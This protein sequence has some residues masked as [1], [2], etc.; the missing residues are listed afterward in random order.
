MEF[1]KYLFRCRFDNEALLPWY[2]GS[3]FRGVFGRALKKVCCAFPVPEQPGGPDCEACDL[4]REC[5][6]TRVFETG[7]AVAPPEGSRVAAVPHPFVIEPPMDGKTQYKAGDEFDF[8]LLLFGEVNRNLPHFIHAFERMGKIGIGRRRQG[9]GGSFCLVS[10]ERDNRILY[11]PEE[12]RVDVPEAVADLR[13]TEAP[14]DALATRRLRVMLETPLRYKKDN[15]L[16]ADIPFVDLTR[17]MLRRVS[18]LMAC[19]GEGGPA[20]DYNGLIER[21]RSVRMVE[22][23]LKWFDWRRYSMR[24]EQEMLMGGVMGSATY[25]G[26]VAEFLPLVRFCEKV[27]LGKQTSFGLGKFVAASHVPGKRRVVG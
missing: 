1:G 21:A 25:E 26:A 5:V 27:H 11:R 4:R 24:Q 15:R 23:S 13:L 17:V 9:D 10:V 2:K 12:G 19:W 7:L 14:A 18:S 16:A 8:H 22:N 3:T 20:L 6:Y